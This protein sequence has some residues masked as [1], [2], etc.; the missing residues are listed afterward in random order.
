M[1]TNS[2]PNTEP[3]AAPLS[4]AENFEKYFRVIVANTKE[5]RHEVFKIRHDVYCR[6]LEWEGEQSSKMETDEYDDYAY[7]FLLQHRISYKY[8]GCIRIII[9]PADKPHLKTP[10]EDNC[11]SSINPEVLDFS[12]LSRGSFG[13]ISRLAVPDTFRRRRNEANKPFA[14]NDTSGG[15]EFTEEERRSFPSIAIGLYLAALKMVSICHHDAGLMMMEP[16]LRR[17]LNR[18]GFAFVQAGEVIEYHGARALFYL[19]A[20]EFFTG[21]NPELLSLFN[22]ISK[23]IDQ[24]MK[25]IPYANPLDH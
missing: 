21:L 1:T 18:F 7:Y 19:P 24:Q 9:P 3:Q 17:Q 25:L 5:L 13:E 2:P 14:M 20:S 23:D 6:E 16:K 15:D 10:F 22:V 4:V 12:Q 8:A 11:L